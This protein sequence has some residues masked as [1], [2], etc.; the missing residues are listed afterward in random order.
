MESSHFTEHGIGIL[1]E[2]FHQQSICM[3]KQTVALRIVYS[4][5]TIRSKGIVC[6]LVIIAIFSGKH[7]PVDC[8]RHHHPTENLSHAGITVVE[9]RITSQLFSPDWSAQ[10]GHTNRPYPLRYCKFPFQ[11][12]CGWHRSRY[13][14]GRQY[15]LP[16]K[17]CC[18]VRYPTSV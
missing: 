15:Q 6:L 1:M 4:Y 14:K 13:P 7:V 11:N 17:P 12:K 2:S 5:G 10:N 8:I 9:K 18:N 3:K 16:S